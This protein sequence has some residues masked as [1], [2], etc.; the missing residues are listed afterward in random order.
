MT[1]ALLIGIS[2]GITSS[3]QSQQATCKVAVVNMQAVIVGTQDGQ[4]A[5][6][7][8]TTKA[9]PKQKE[10]ETRQNEIMQLEDQLRKGGNLMS[11]SKREE[12]TRLIDEKKK[13]LDRDVQD[14]NENL[15]AEQQRLLQAMGQKIM[16]V[17]TQYAKDSQYS[18]VM[19]DSSPNTPVMY[20]PSAL[21]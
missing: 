11:D 9:A 2:G 12:L 17:V 20:R 5:Q 3:G 8:L 13:R 21:T 6:Q 15:Q 7:E 14:A 19:D 4:T 16:A 18:I 1:L 10:F